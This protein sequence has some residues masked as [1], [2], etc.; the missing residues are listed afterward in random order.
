MIEIFNLF[1]TEFIRSPIIL[2]YPNDPIGQTRIVAI[3]IFQMILTYYNN[4]WRHRPTTRINALNHN[5]PFPIARLYSFNFPIP[6]VRHYNKN[7]YNLAYKKT[8]LVEIPD[9][10]LYNIMLGN[11]ILE[12]LKPSFNDLWIF[13][14]GPLIIVRTIPMYIELWLSFDEVGSPT[15]SDVYRVVYRQ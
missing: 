6:I 8:C 2:V 14:L 13:V 10:G 7:G 11:H 12:K 5:D 15:Q 3:P 1:E 9:I 4:K